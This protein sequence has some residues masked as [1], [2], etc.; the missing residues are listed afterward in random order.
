VT[1]AKARKL[2]EGSVPD[3]DPQGVERGTHPA[4]D[5]AHPLSGEEPTELGPPVRPPGGG[6]FTSS[7]VTLEMT[8]SLAGRQA[9]AD[10][11]DS[12]S[13]DLAAPVADPLIGVVVAE[14]Y[15]ILELLGRGGMGIVYRVEHTR[16]GKL[17]A[18]KLLTGELSR[19][20]EVVRRF[21]HEALTASKLSSPNTVQVFDFGVSEGLTYLV[22]ELVA[23]EDLGRTLRALG[24]MPTARL[25]RII[26]QVCSSLAEAHQKTIV[27]RDI[28]PENIMLLRTRD[29]ADIAKV[30]DFGLAKI[31]EGSELNDVT[32]QGAIVG[33]PYF[34]SPE[35]VRG[36]PVDA[37]SDIYSLGAVM[38][39]AITGH[40]PFNGPTP[41]AVFT[42]HLTETPP[43]PVDRVPALGISRTMND[44]IMRALSKPQSDRYQRIEDLQADLLDELRSLSSSS[45]DALVDSGAVREIQK[46]AS[47]S[48]LSG[49]A[50]VQVGPEEI[51]TR[52]EVERYERKLRRKRWGLFAF[53]VGVPIAA[54]AWGV[55]Y[56]MNRPTVFSGLE[57]E[58][59]DSAPLATPV[60]FGRGV[61]GFIG[62]RVD[63]TSGDRD[64]FAVDVP[65][66]DAEGGTT[67]VELRVGSL[68]NFPVCT[69][70]YAHGQHLAQAQ[71][72][73]GRPSRDL[74]IEALRLPPGKYLLAVMQ[75]LDPYGAPEPPYVHENVSD[76]YELTLAIAG[77]D[78]GVEVEPNDKVPSAQRIEP[79]SPIRGALGWVA[80]ED[81]FCT[82]G[83]EGGAPPSGRASFRVDD[84][85]REPGV[86]LEITP[87]IASEGVSSD[88]SLPVRVHEPAKQG[89][90][91]LTDQ[92]V[93]S[94]WESEA[95]ELA[96]GPSC[97]KLRLAPDPW[98]T[99]ASPAV[100]KGS[101]ET[102]R[103]TLEPA[104]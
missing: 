58:P 10:I 20:A 36:D 53:I 25:A 67:T 40:Y 64:F 45:V 98:T 69:F 26:V 74:V 21:K 14:R 102:Y 62:K 49:V 70:L 104:P 96:S 97:V 12:Q 7:S 89:Q 28:K 22:M 57:S 48:E 101:H 5:S 88:E 71:Y 75:D 59:N 93:A 52:D 16:I 4:P 65:T 31:R 19:N 42:K 82:A 81:V 27:H 54:A 33:T 87:V 30:L 60:P 11:R 47:P 85:K 83:S 43:A 103:I 37:R 44:I 39:R 63:D 34:M 2:A 78:G 17:L 80:D 86:V 61:T 13:F 92:D 1:T 95:F 56:Y 72:C 46:A 24:P 66:S 35:Q 73:V 3:G 18:M 8:A 91:A 6:A 38:Y 55:R 100:P 9:A 99:G 41:M 15:R 76:A 77:S 84:T 29:G 94:P 51:A 90:P 50:G 23:G 68:P 79:N 32:S